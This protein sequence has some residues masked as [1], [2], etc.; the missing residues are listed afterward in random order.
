[1]ENLFFPRSISTVCVITIILFFGKHFKKL[2]RI[3]LNNFSGNFSRIF[4]DEILSSPLENLKN[5]FK[6]KYSKFLSFDEMV[7][8]TSAELYCLRPSWKK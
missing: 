1:M 4:L 5:S 7:L 3:F 6:P 8:C 2:I